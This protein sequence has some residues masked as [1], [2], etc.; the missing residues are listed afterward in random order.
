MQVIQ[1]EPLDDSAAKWLAERVELIQCP[2]GD[3]SFSAHISMA[4]GMVVRTY[5]IVDETLLKQAPKLKVIGRAGV[6]VD[7]ID[8]DACAA[9]GVTVVYTPDANT[10][11]V[12]DYVTAA[13]M[14]N[15]IPTDSTITT[16]MP[17]KQWAAFRNENVRTRQ[18]DELTLGII[19]FGRIGKRV[20]RAATGIGLRVIYNDLLSFSPEQRFDA[21]PVLMEQLLEES[22]IISMHIDGRDA[23]RGLINADLFAQMKRDVLFINTSRGRVVDATAAAAFLKANPDA[24]AV[25]DVH[26]PE[27]VEDDY[28]LLGIPN[29]IL[30]PHVAGRTDT[31]L[32]QMSEVVRDVYA[33]LT[34]E[35]PKHI[36]ENPMSG[37]LTPDY[38]DMTN[39]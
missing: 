29:A 8:L 4:D 32:R 19:G 36:F 28:P 34:G 37:H 30:T 15:C 23:N 25:I 9:H 3:P 6:G 35:T 39:T 12:V 11:A 38:F 2:L 7:N 18:L 20:A 14:R 27:P 26:N 10:Q 5:T 24:T 22:D 33:V 17:L 21:S 31:G 13:I 16:A 1:T